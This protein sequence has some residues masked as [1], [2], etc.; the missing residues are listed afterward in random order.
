[1]DDFTGRTAERRR[2]AVHRVA[3]GWSPTDVATFLGV[4]V[5]TVRGWVRTHKAGGDDALATRPRS[6]RPNHLSPRQIRQVLGWLLRQP[7]EF[8]FRTDLWTARR[9]A[10]LI[11]QKFG[12]DYNP[13]YL[14]AWLTRHGQSPQK[15]NRPAVE[16]DPAKVAAFVETEWPTLQKKATPK[17]RT[18]SSSTK[19]A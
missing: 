18:S 5:E 2:W 1:M 12:V 13:N 7:S 9:V 19:R 8:G 3:A 17:R 4:H 10:E 15:P 16:R 14:R 11:R 6:G